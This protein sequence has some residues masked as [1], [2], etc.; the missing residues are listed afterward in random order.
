MAVGPRIILRPQR[1]AEAVVSLKARVITVVDTAAR[2]HQAGESPLC[3]FL[4]VRRKR[5]LAGAVF[6]TGE[7]TKGPLEGVER[8]DYRKTV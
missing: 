3:L 7:F 2:E 1:K 6:D 5:N 8:S 4:I